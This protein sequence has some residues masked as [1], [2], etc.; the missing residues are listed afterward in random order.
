MKKENR[1]LAQ[2]RRAEERRIM[3]QRKK[4]KKYL[5]FGLPVAALII[6]IIVLAVYN[7]NGNSSSKENDTSESSTSSTGNNATESTGLSTDE[8]LAV[9]NGDTVSIDYIGSVDG[10]EFDGG[11]TKGNGTDLV[12]GSNTY[13]DDFEEQLIGHHPGETVDVNVTFPENYG[14]DNL[15]GKDALF[16]V[17]INGIY[18]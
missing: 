18:Q 1:K 14:K 13:I 2:E 10:V 3:E 8:S 15:N 12:I 17:T 5:A 16:K 6:L 4:L 7:S 9:K 11:S